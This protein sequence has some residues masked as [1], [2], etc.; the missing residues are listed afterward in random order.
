M[1]SQLARTE[2]KFCCTHILSFCFSLNQDF[3]ECIL[4]LDLDS[5]QSRPAAVQPVAI[6]PG[7]VLI[8]PGGLPMHP[9]YLHASLQRAPGHLE[10]VMP[11]VRPPQLLTQPIKKYTVCQHHTLLQNMHKKI[12]TPAS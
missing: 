3:T 1:Y 6:C 5:H 12:T 2:E 7:A 11:T 9:A 4:T 8:S 10:T